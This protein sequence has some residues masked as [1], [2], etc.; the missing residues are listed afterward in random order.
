MKDEY[1]ESGTW[2]FLALERR[3]KSHT[4]KT[5]NYLATRMA[6]GG[7]ICE[8]AIIATGYALFAQLP[9]TEFERLKQV[10]HIRGVQ[11]TK[12]FLEWYHKQSKRK[13]SLESEDDSTTISEP[14]EQDPYGLG[15]EDWKEDPSTPKIQAIWQPIDNAE[16]LLEPYS[17]THIGK[18]DIT[19]MGRYSEMIFRSAD[20]TS[21]DSLRNPILGSGLVSLLSPVTIGR[22][23]DLGIAVHGF[24]HY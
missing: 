24:L 13:S 18:A 9:S 3:I 11:T 14:E 21:S 7:I 17:F 8:D 23:E 20:V 15:F 16:D 10:G 1:M 4:G 22:F 12:D 6:I 2:E 19:V 5:G